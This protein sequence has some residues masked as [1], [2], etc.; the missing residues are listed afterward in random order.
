MVKNSLA[1]KQQ[2]LNSVL[3]DSYLPLHKNCQLFLLLHN[4][5]IYLELACHDKQNGGQQIVLQQSLAK[6]WQFNQ[7]EQNR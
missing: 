6:I 7:R 2:I 1:T 4:I 5:Y 3:I